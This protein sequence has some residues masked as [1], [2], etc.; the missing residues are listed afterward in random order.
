MTSS[1][2]KMLRDRSRRRLVADSAHAVI[3]HSEG[4][5]KADSIYL[6]IPAALLLEQ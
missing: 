6:R 1:L 5:K 2:S 4:G 3:Y